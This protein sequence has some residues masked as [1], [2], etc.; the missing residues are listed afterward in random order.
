MHHFNAI[1]LSTM[2]EILDEATRLVLRAKPQWGLTDLGDKV[3]LWP[4]NLNSYLA[5]TAPISDD[6]FRKITKYLSDPRVAAELERGLGSAKAARRARFAA[7]AK[8]QFLSGHDIIV[9]ASRNREPTRA[10]ESFV[11][12]AMETSVSYQSRHHG[13]FVRLSW[14]AL[15]DLLTVIVD[16]V[17]KASG[18][19]SAFSN[20]AALFQVMRRLPISGV[21][22]SLS[23]LHLTYRLGDLAAQ[24]DDW[25]LLEEIDVHL[26]QLLSEIEG[27]ESKAYCRRM[28]DEY[29]SLRNDRYSP[30]KRL[31]FAGSA[32]GRLASAPK[33]HLYLTQD[34]ARLHSGWVST[35]FN[36]VQTALPATRTQSQANALRR[37]F[38]E[39]LRELGI[40]GA[41]SAHAKALTAPD[42]WLAQLIV[43]RSLCWRNAARNPSGPD[44][45]TARSPSSHSLSLL[46]QGNSRGKKRS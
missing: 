21:T 45:S 24:F 42:P 43:C 30:K 17:R 15:S 13:R 1:Y 35:S 20:V 3:A 31:V 9:H 29:S 37:R 4:Q 41:M 23:A 18:Q 27:R 12:R 25:T 44:T 11:Y 46:S 33:R 16:D 7:Q 14:D 36:Y 19:F 8:R 28:L 39:S 5:G 26:R 2:E 34:F 32:I 10:Y 6:R 38:D 40:A 22:Q